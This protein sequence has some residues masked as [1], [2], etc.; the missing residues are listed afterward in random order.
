MPK[1][2]S[3]SSEASVNLLPDPSNVAGFPLSEKKAKI[4]RDA[5]GNFR[6]IVRRYYWCGGTAILKR[7][8]V[9]I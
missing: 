2:I 9:R 5:Y 7:T 8:D 1:T 6:V 3:L 4:I